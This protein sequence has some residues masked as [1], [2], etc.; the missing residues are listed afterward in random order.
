MLIDIDR[1]DVVFGDE[2]MALYV[3]GELAVSGV[4]LTFADVLEHLKMKCSFWEADLD[5]YKDPR[6]F[7]RSFEDIVYPGENPFEEQLEAN[8][9]D[10]S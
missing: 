2:A 5:V 9:D 8:V 3:D 10:N 4:K 1:V 6:A 7:P